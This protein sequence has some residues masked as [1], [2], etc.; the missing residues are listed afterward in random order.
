MKLND[1]LKALG[2]EY[3]VAYADLAAKIAGHAAQAADKAGK[4]KDAKATVWGDFKTALTLASE[5]GHTVTA[6]RVGLEIACIEA[7]IAP[8]TFRSYVATVADLYTDVLDE[9]K[10]FTLEQAT[11]ISIADARKRYKTETPVQMMHAKLKDAIKDW[12]AEQLAILLSLVAD[13]NGDAAKKDDEGTDEGE[14][15]QDEARTG[16]DG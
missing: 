16:T 1:G 14:E 7:D 8:G 12:D 9:E 4:A 6:L 15:T 5:A 10:E 13:I 2:A 3:A 11:V